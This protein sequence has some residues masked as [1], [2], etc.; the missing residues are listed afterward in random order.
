MFAPYRLTRLLTM[1]LAA[2][3]ATWAM[4]GVALAKPVVLPQPAATHH[5]P[6]FK[7]VVGDRKE[8]EHPARPAFKVAPGDVKSDADRA[9]AVAPPLTAVAVRATAPAAPA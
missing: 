9:R 4:S 5:R 3:A 8:P 7:A 6:D 2:C 1:A